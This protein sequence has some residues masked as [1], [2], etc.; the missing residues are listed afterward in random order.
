MTGGADLKS[1]TRRAVRSGSRM[2]IAA[3][4]LAGV[5]ITAASADAASVSLTWNAP[6]TNAD[7]SALTDLGSYRIYLGTATPSCP[8]ASFLTVAS[9]T[10]T[11]PNGQVVSTRVASLT[12]GATYFVRISAVDSAGN[13]S[14]CST[15]ASGVAQTDF[16]VT[17]TSTT[18]FGSITVGSS[19]D[20]TFTVQNTST[21]SITGTASAGAPYS[22]VSGGSFSLAAGASQVVTVRFRPSVA[23]TFAGNVTFTASGD[24]ASRVLTG[25]GIAVPTAALSVT[26]AGT[27]AGTVTS[28]PAG[29]SCGSSCSATVPIGTAVT[30]TAAAAS[31]STFM[32]WGGACGGTTACTW[33]MSANAA[34]TASFDNTRVDRPL[35][36]APVPVAGSLSPATAITGSPALTLTVNGSGFAASSVVRWNGADR[37]TTVVS[38]TQLTAAI[39]AADLASARS[40][41]VTVFTPAPGGGTSN[42][43]TFTVTAAPAAPTLSSLSPT[44]AA[45][46]GAAFT[47]IVNGKHFVGASVVRWNGTDRTTTFVSAG[48]LHAAIT[49]ADLATARS[50]PVTV[51]TPAP[52]GGTSSVK[53]FTVF[54]PPTAPVP[55]TPPALP[56]VPGNLS[57]TQTTTDASGATFT[58]AWAGVSGATSYKWVAAFTDG[59]AAQ[60]GAV[61]SAS[62]QLR[63]PYHVSGAAS[64]GFVCVRSANAAGQSADQSCATLSV[65]ARPV[66]LP[67]PVPVTSSLSPA[68]A[69]S[70]SADLTLTVNGSS[71]VASSVVRWNGADR[72]TTFVSATQLR[73][74][75]TAADLV[76]VRTVPVTVFTPT[77]GGGTSASKSFSVTTPQFVPA[78]LPSLPAVPLNLSVTPPATDASGATFTVAWAGVSGATSYRYTAAFND[79]TAAQQ[80]AVAG[81]LSF[82]LRMPYHA[83][84]AAFGG[85]VCVRSV[86]A[87]GQSADQSCIPLSV[88]ARPASAPVPVASSLSPASAVAG[89]AGITLTVNG[90]GFGASS[91][92]RWNGIARATT[93]VSATQLRIAVTAV[94]LASPGSASVSVFTPAPGGGTSGKVTFTIAAPAPLPQVPAALPAI[95][96]NPSVSPGTADAGGV[97]FAIAW[98]SASGATSYRYVAAF[99]DGSGLQQ[100]AVTSPSLQLRMPYHWSGAAFNGFVCIRSVNAAGQ[101]ADQ[102]CNALSVPAR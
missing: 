67:V 79:G 14:S 38:A 74:A 62:L 71:F 52:G 91:A 70:G 101:S 89:D 41:P 40:V 29:I 85:Y 48:Q 49:P 4:T 5:I 87:A 55:S 56:A 13:E 82:Q 17:P 24:T 36:P 98:S 84:G 80:G 60:Q 66:S 20:A 35:Q 44:G 99:N 33:T 15:S 28:V 73:A 23:G 51:F 27:G 77:P 34:V 100:G 9:P 3:L 43:V 54:A 45:A 47:L 69:S 57:V 95:P 16:S 94:D 2:V 81:L 65:P 63:M 68:S 21:T 76:T 42:K 90:N 19:A 102:A 10:S 18:N 6:T 92:V 30:L 25:T 83:S 58:I 37:T 93:L 22:I 31:G 12:A 61:T 7:G 72:P 32:G 1:P 39:T 97:T 64:S 59:S 78:P 75:I 86:N 11:P 50:V 8:S 96:G 46:G 53:S 88:P 26:T